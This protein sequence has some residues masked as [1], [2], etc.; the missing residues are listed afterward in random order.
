MSIVSKDFDFF[1]ILCED[2]D[3]ARSL[4]CSILVKYN[5]WDQLVSLKVDPS[6]YNTWD[7]EGFKHDYQITE[8]FR[9]CDD[10]PTSFD[11]PSITEQAFWAAE[12]QCTI[13]NLR[14][15]TLR[16][17]M[18]TGIRYPGNNIPWF[19]TDLVT[20]IRDIVRDVLRS[21]PDELEPK[22]SS[23]STFHDRRHTLPQDKMS[24][25]PTGT[26]DCVAVIE[27][28]WA[29]T[30]WF[31]GLVTEF[32]H[33]SLP[34]L[35]LGNRFT[36][37]PKS[38]TANRGICVEPSLNVTY[39]LA[40]GS[41]IRKRLYRVGLDLKSGQLKHARCMSLASKERHIATIDLSSAS[42]TVSLELVRL[43]LPN[44][45]FDLLDSLRSQ[46]TF[47]AGK[48]HKNAKFS[49]MGNGF[50]FELETLIFYAIATSVCILLGED[51]TLVSVYGDDIIVPTPAAKAVVQALT[52]FG[53]T[54]NMRKT[55][56]NA[57][58]FR[59]SCGTDSFNG[60]IIRKYHVKS[61][62]KN[63]VDW[64]A[65][66]N[67]IRRLASYELSNFNSLYCYKR[68]WL[69]ALCHIPTH[70]RKIRGPAYLGDSVIH[71]WSYDIVSKSDGN[72]IRTV[73]LQYPKGATTSYDRPFWSRDS[74]IAAATS[75]LLRGSGDKIVADQCIP[76]QQ[77]K[78]NYEPIGYK[79]KLIRFYTGDEPGEP[80]SLS[81]CL[82][83]RLG[84]IS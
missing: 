37:V 44:E 65:I 79:I 7:I 27:P 26:P 29:Q 47:I 82:A 72:Y 71:D 1:H 73:R 4:T 17:M 59:E 43:L 67:G 25:R 41:V 84:I 64:I 56:I 49:S 48:W 58:P 46:Q 31:R 57:V 10:L 55:F 6:E 12:H 14:L 23:G 18:H 66:T 75:G 77:R 24:S 11:L 8:L 9:K 38:A 35:V 69:R 3:R 16:N 60:H 53:F 62:P 51:S 5:E 45:W 61:L 80:D 52:F 36:Q 19:A 83:S 78:R 22:F 15:S 70:I 39:Q 68:A 40:V 74:I 21:I 81:Y 32:P 34:R 28:F 33:R 76:G 30:L 42:D 54:P 2:M 63:P 50:T 13:T 20:L